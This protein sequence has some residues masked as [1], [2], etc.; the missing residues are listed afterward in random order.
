MNLQSTEDLNHSMTRREA[1]YRAILIDTVDLLTNLLVYQDE[2][3]T[4]A[5]KLQVDAINVL[6]GLEA[7]G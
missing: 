4:F 3:S 6:L 1:T 5:A 2:D 7:Q